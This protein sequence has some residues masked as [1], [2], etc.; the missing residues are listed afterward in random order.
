MTATSLNSAIKQH[1]QIIM[2]H[3]LSTNWE[4]V[5]TN[6]KE[7]EKPAQGAV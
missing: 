5:R 7:M 4:G 6:G 3:F 2:N 1:P